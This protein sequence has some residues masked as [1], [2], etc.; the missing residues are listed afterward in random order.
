MSR[1]KYKTIDLFA[2]I[3][4]IRRGFELTGR[5]R[6]VLSAEV[7]KY[8]CITYK[9][10][11]GD[12][13]TNDVTSDEFKKKIRNIGY[14]VLLAGFP[15][16]PF[17]IAGKKDGFEDKTRGTLFFEIAS[18][19][20]ETRP[21]AFLLENVG[22]LITHRKGRTLR[23]ILETLVFELNYRVIGVERN[24]NDL[25]YDPS[26]FI[27]NSKHFG[28]P[29]N[30]PRAYIIGFNEEMV[31]NG[32]LFPE[33]PRKRNDLNLYSDIDDLLD[34]NVDDAFYIPEGYLQT[35]ERH[36][37]MHKEKGNGFGYVVVNL[38]K[39]EKIANALLAT[40]GS[41]K[42]RNIVYQPKKGVGGK[43]IPR[44]KSPL[45][46]RG[47]RFMTPREWGKLQGFVGYAFVDKN[48]N[49]SFSF[50]SSVPMTQQ[51][52]LLGNSV[53]IPVIEKLAE[54]MAKVL[55]KITANEK[56]KAW[57]E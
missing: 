22:G 3:G 54:Y 29:Q 14:D 47:L 16:Q 35:L 11:F 40:G 2:G 17:S 15:C 5:Y 4:G 34:K 44:K 56:M 28:V 26:F 57:S 30:R 50:P 13:P 7:D 8:A 18:I 43:M 27:L 1:R 45:N 49:D 9:H 52:K 31:P 24:G 46:D 20:K 39:K 48:G 41:G 32:Y 23:V 38:D 42:E 36:R 53:T 21:K 25:I 55:D 37:K 51:Y 33:I 10:L 12:D 19:M 6:N